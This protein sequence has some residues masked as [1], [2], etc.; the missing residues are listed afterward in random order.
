MALDIRRY[1]QDDWAAICRIHDTARLD[2]LRS[3]V[4]VEA[5]LTLADTYE[6]E[7]LFSNPVWVA[8][9]DG[10]V[11][12]FI[13]ASPSEITWIYVDPA[14]YRR[15]VARALMTEVLIHAGERVELE[16]LDGNTAAWSFYESLGFVW[17]SSTTGKLT[18]NERFEATGHTL[19]WRRAWPARDQR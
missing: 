7:D 14:L 9:L 3:S 18:G 8:E 2:E 4:G 16:V 10:S 5:F 12:G 15:G 17:E 6:N 19:V 1:R 11:A 13:A